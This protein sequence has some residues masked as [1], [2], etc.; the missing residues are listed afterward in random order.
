MGNNEDTNTVTA[1]GSDENLLVICCYCG[2][3]ILNFSN[4]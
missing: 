3:F 4:L 1:N 2:A